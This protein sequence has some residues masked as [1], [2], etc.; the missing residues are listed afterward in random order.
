MPRYLVFTGDGD[1]LGMRELDCEN[2]AIGDAIPA[3]PSEMF[4]VL[5]VLEAEELIERRGPLP[6]AAFKL[7][8]LVV[9]RITV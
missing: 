7:P 5:D 1:A 9:D 3:G 6:A 4:R 8:S 2:V